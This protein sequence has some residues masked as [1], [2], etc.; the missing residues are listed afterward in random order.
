MVNL[1]KKALAK[2]QESFQPET[3]PCRNS[4]KLKI[5]RFINSSISHSGNTNSLYISGLPGLGKTA[6]VHE[7]VKKIKNSTK[8]QFKF[9]Q[10]NCLKLK[11]ANDFYTFLLK[12]MIGV[13]K[14]NDEARSILYSFF[15]L[16]EWPKFKLSSKS[17]RMRKGFKNAVLAEDTLLLLV[18]E[19]DYLITR[20]QEILYN[21]FNWTHEPSS[22]ISVICIANT[23]DFPEKLMAKIG[24]RIGHKR[25][26]F[27]PYNSKNLQQI[28]ANRLQDVKVFL[29]DAIRFVS[30][31][32]A[33]YSS[34]VRKSLHICRLA[35]EISLS[36]SKA[37]EMIGSGTINKAFELYYSNVQVS[38]IQS[39][40]LPV[41][42]ILA[43]LISLFKNNSVKIVDIFKFYEKYRIISELTG[44]HLFTFKQFL[45]MVRNLAAAGILDLKMQMGH[46]AEVSLSVNT[47]QVE[48]ALK[49]EK[50]ITSVID[51][52]S[53]R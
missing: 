6:C 46:H 43:A 40:S 21:L 39:K 4:E 51:L 3:M 17:R 36:R 50:K 11:S 18:D 27:S 13:E 33:A 8:Q 53:I 25:L 42:I 52:N 2:L 9:L 41:K 10:L 48:F 34:D 5:R 31:K 37:Q 49:E 29:P 26:I 30:K 15:T 12:L 19:I 47:D 38:F 32:I 16:G 24:S 22:R 14:K 23:L 28:M 45:S 44:T 1:K 7:V 20:D 35:I